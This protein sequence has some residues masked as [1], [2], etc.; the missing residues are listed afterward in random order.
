MV[1]VQVLRVCGAIILVVGEAARCKTKSWV[2]D[3]TAQTVTLVT[4]EGVTPAHR[5]KLVAADIDFE[6]MV[7]VQVL[8]VCGAIIL[9][10]GEAAR[11]KTKTR[12]KGAIKHT[13]LHPQ[14]SRREIPLVRKK[15]GHRFDRADRDTSE[16]S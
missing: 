1:V 13:R 3:S 11:C 12:A 5:S 14:C 10:V 8:R 4:P 9:V 7:V 6:C 16:S 2:I 15:L